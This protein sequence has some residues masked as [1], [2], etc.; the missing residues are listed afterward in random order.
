MEISDSRFDMKLSLRPP[1]PTTLPTKV[2][3]RICMHLH[4]SLSIRLTGLSFFVEDGQP[5]TNPWPDP[6]SSSYFHPL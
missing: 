1:V 3:C 4:I 2:L 5:V 6:S